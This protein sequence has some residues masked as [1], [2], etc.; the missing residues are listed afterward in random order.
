MESI[1]LLFT[2]TLGAVKKLLHS[3]LVQNSRN[4][5]LLFKIFHL[6]TFDVCTHLGAKTG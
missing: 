6:N 5:S 4:D 3:K 2:P 1:N